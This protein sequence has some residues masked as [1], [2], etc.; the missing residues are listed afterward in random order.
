MPFVLEGIKNHEAVEVSK[1]SIGCLVD[2]CSSVSGGIQPYCDNIMSVLTDMLHDTSVYRS[3]KPPLISCLGDIA[4]AICGAYEPYLQITTML[5]MQ[6]AQQTPPPDNEEMIDFINTLRCAVLEAYSGILLGL[7]DGNKLQLFAP[8]VQ[9]L[10][11]F[12]EWLTNPSSLRDETVL[13]KAVTLLGDIARE[14]PT[15]PQVK[16]LVA[17][18]FVQQLLTL[19]ANIGAEGASSANWTNEQIQAVLRKG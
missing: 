4:M 10:G 12:L 5:L 16:A 18:P 3:L 6:A 13:P 17:Q 19:C 8:N 1:V 2:I 9:Q 14:M 7:S 15:D 11:L